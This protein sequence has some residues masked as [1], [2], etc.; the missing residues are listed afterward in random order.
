[1]SPFR[2]ER[3]TIE[4][5]SRHRSW[6]LTE[7]LGNAEVRDHRRDMHGRCQ[8]GQSAGVVVWCHYDRLGLRHRE[9]PSDLSGR[10]EERATNGANGLGD[11][12]WM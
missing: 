7:I 2:Q 4:A 1:M 6:K 11:A 3:V 10:P 12:K 9:G 5:M 8:S